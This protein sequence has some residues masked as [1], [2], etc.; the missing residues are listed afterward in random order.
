LK[1]PRSFRVNRIALGYREFSGDIARLA[2][3]NELSYDLSESAILGY[4]GARIEIIKATNTELTYKV[5]SG[6]IQ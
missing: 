3:S 6:F 1:H 4:K 5:I 2:F